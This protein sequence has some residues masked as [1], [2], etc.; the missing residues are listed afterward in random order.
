MKSG[1]IGMFAHVAQSAEHTL[2]KG[3]VGGSSPLVGLKKTEV[4]K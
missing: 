3:E 1:C 2:G 4:A